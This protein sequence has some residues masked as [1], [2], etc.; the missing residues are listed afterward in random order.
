[1]D[2]MKSIQT[3]YI[4]IPE[5][6]NFCLHVFLHLTEDVS[7]KRI[8]HLEMELDMEQPKECQ[9]FARLLKNGHRK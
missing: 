9:K 8:N 7:F 3:N 6:F 1:M 2:A 4:Q 5:N